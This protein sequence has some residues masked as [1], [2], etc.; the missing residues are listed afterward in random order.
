MYSTCRIPT[1]QASRQSAHR[2]DDAI[3][4]LDTAHLLIVVHI[5]IVEAREKRAGLNEGKRERGGCELEYYL[6]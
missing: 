4:M 6:L 2:S 5:M 1:K 3:Q